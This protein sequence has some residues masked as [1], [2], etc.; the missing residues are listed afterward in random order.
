MA[1]KKLA[2]PVRRRKN[3][4]PSRIPSVNY[5][6][7]THDGPYWAAALRATNDGLPPFTWWDVPRMTADPT[8]KLGLA[9]R[10]ALVRQ[11]GWEVWCENEQAKD[12]INRTIQTFWDRIAPMMLNQYF[13]WGFSCA[14]PMYR[15]LNGFV[16]LTGARLVTPLHG[17]PHIWTSGPHNGQF[18][19]MDLGGFGLDSSEGPVETP[20]AIWFGG[21]EARCPLYDYS[22][23]AGAWPS[24]LEKNT[25]G[26]AIDTRR[27]YFRRQAIPPVLWRVPLGPADPSD[28]ESISCMDW[29]SELVEN[30]ENNT[31]YIVPDIRVPGING[32]S[33]QQWSVE[34]MGSAGQAVDIREYVKDLDKEMLRGMGIPPEVLDSTDTGGG[35]SGRQIPQQGLYAITDQLVVPLLEAVAHCILRELVPH[36]FGEGV[37]WRVTNVPLVECIRRQEQQGDIQG[38]GQGGEQVQGGGPVAPGEGQAGVGD[39]GQ[40][41]GAEATASGLVPYVGPH[42]GV[43]EKNPVTGKVY[44]DTPGISTDYQ[45]GAPRHLSHSPSKSHK[46][47]GCLIAELPEP[48]RSYITAFGHSIPEDE[49]A[50]EGVE[51][52]PHVTIRHGLTDSPENVFGQTD[53]LGLLHGVP[54]DLQIF[55][56]KDADVLYLS[57]GPEFSPFNEAVSDCQGQPSKWPAYVPHATVAYL[58]PGE[59][60][61][62]IGR[63]IPGVVPVDIR[64][65]AYHTADGEC[66]KRDL[67]PTQDHL[68]SALMDG[69][70]RMEMAN[71]PNLTRGKPPTEGPKQ[72]PK[73]KSGVEQTDQGVDVERPQITPKPV[74]DVV[75]PAPRADQKPN[76]ES[77]GTPPSTPVRSRTSSKVG[78]FIS[79]YRLNSPNQNISGAKGHLSDEIAGY[80]GGN[81]HARK[82]ADSE[83]QREEIER[84]HSAFHAFT[85]LAHPEYQKFRGLHEQAEPQAPNQGSTEA[86]GGAAAP[87]QQQA[88]ANNSVQVGPPKP[89]ATQPKPQ[90]T[91]P[92]PQQPASAPAQPNP[93]QPPTKQSPPAAQPVKPQQ[94]KRVEQPNPVQPPATQTQAPATPAKP[95][96][97]AEPKVDGEKTLGD[98][99]A[100]KKAEPPK[101]QAQQA[102]RFTDTAWENHAAK[103][104]DGLEHHG[105][106]DD[107]KAVREAVTTALNEAMRKTGDAIREG[108]V[109][110]TEFTG[111][112][113]HDV[114]LPSGGRIRATILPGVKGGFRYQLGIPKSKPGEVADP[115]NDLADSL[116]VPRTK[117]EDL[118]PQPQPESQNEALPT[119]PQAEPQSG[120]GAPDQQPKATP[121]VTSEPPV[122]EQPPVTEAPGGQPE[123]I[124]QPQLKAEATAPATPESKNPTGEADAPEERI[125]PEGNQQQH[126]Q[127][128]QGGETAGPS[129]SDR[130]LE[131]GQEQAPEVK[132]EVAPETKQE[133]KPEAQPEQPKVSLEESKKSA[134]QEYLHQKQKL[135][136]R[137]SDGLI[138][139]EQHKEILDNVAEMERTH[140]GL[141]PTDW[142]PPQEPATEP[143]VETPKETVK[144][145]PPPE[146]NVNADPKK[147]AGDRMAGGGS[148]GSSPTSAPETLA[149]PRTAEVQ[150]KAKSEPQADHGVK[151]DGTEPTDEGPAAPDHM[152]GFKFPS[153]SHRQT[154]DFLTSGVESSGATPEQK[155]RFHEAAYHVASSI[156]ESEHGRLRQSLGGGVRYAKDK[157]SLADDFTRIMI[158]HMEKFGESPSQRKLLEERQQNPDSAAGFYYPEGKSLHINGPSPGV[159]LGGNL[160]D[161]DDEVLT[162]AHEIGHALDRIVSGKDGKISGSL[163]QQKEFKDIFDGLVHLSKNES[164]SYT[165]R[166]PLSSYAVS[167]P[168]ELFAEFSRLIYSGY[169]NLDRVQKQFPELSEFFKKNNLW[170]Q[171][172]GDIDPSHFKG[173]FDPSKR[174]EIDSQGGHLD[175]F[176]EKPEQETGM[177]KPADS[178]SPEAPKKP[179]PQPEQPKLPAKPEPRK[180]DSAV[181]RK[182]LAQQMEM[183]FKSR[184]SSNLSPDDRG[185]FKSTYGMTDAELDSAIGEVHKARPDLA[186]EKKV[187]EPKKGATKK[188]VDEDEGSD[189]DNDTGAIGDYENGISDIMSDPKTTPQEKAALK[190]KLMADLKEKHGLEGQFGTNEEESE[191]DSTENLA[192]KVADATES[193]NFHDLASL[194][195]SIP[196]SD[197]DLT[198]SLR[199]AAEAMGIKVRKNAVAKTLL[200]AIKDKLRS[201]VSGSTGEKTTESHPDDHWVSSALLG[202][203]SP[204]QTV[205]RAGEVQSLA[206]EAYDKVT[207]GDKP[208]LEKLADRSALFKPDGSPDADAVLQSLSRLMSGGLKTKGSGGLTETQKKIAEQ[209]IK[210]AQ[211]ER[212][213]DKEEGAAKAYE[214]ATKQSAEKTAKEGGIG[215][216]PETTKVEQKPADKP[217]EPPAKPESTPSEYPGK[218][219]K[220][221][222]YDQAT[223]SKKEKL[224]RFIKD[225]V[226]MGFTDSDWEQ[227]LDELGVKNPSVSSSGGPDKAPESKKNEPEKPQEVK[228]PEQKQP[229]PKKPA[230]PPAKK[231]DPEESPED[232]LAVSAKQPYRDLVKTPPA[233]VAS[234]HGKLKGFSLTNPD[235]LDVVKALR[236]HPDKFPPETLD[237]VAKLIK[238]DE[239]DRKKA[240]AKRK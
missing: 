134:D 17:R 207:A 59:G 220:L 58:K 113:S 15:Q 209:T 214:D 12:W 64:Q 135:D 233:D 102:R 45:G 42:G 20:W 86:G 224:D 132:P 183:A 106:T 110:P 149:T 16:D 57:M 68:W 8:I 22:L 14:L 195:D 115:L 170:P 5:R 128:G 184:G 118:N 9:M 46:G 230:K 51:T 30:S 173:I 101:Q 194:P 7:N 197:L 156:P 71:K 4:D 141:G 232:D 112:V 122:A 11:G 99:L 65:L 109:D 202:T 208:L 81:K 39:P 61:K 192:K 237:E 215:A 143:K 191:S 133:I 231:A 88:E 117:P 100:P 35:Y 196:N 70:D 76:T 213:S 13:A 31:T 97:K 77:P 160:G 104:L 95:A 136:Q 131:V 159:Y 153:E 116:G 49:L 36:N 223:P 193:R 219:L 176:L 203:S 171:H 33:E 179:E 69:S 172:S 140:R 80:L 114:T 188:L 190:E 164:L 28:P 218:F 19:G 155:A 34:P 72:P 236:Q 157:K 82:E 96:P 162:Y 150:D 189:A 158:N 52:N 228:A 54:G 187:D 25:R 26:G 137:L 198:A 24:W 146:G 27:T 108:G 180:T 163:S 47:V 121:P 98:I 6:P 92:K 217:L 60:E 21:L 201:S 204:Q 79:D 178:P 174:Q 185:Y 111:K 67:W 53:K 168:S 186:V 44:Y 62:Y 85:G 107:H 152:P 55:H 74:P 167:K 129:G 147:M 206:K 238:K 235:R 120:A 216:T 234:L 29:A 38:A 200:G 138:T 205:E 165:K 145:I 89:P 37:H 18:F 2:V 182:D 1:K 84:M 175:V 90:Q 3:F 103:L 166:L 105:F 125:E 154:Y 225:A 222:G 148:G 63:R 93:A 177:R 124:Q 226:G 212:L 181:M 240:A 78:S 48:V 41:G 227:A 169:Y 73:P 130:P 142:T 210:D 32:G 87:Q 43:G 161:L 229:E 211:G 66:F 94:A 91:Q 56:N 151:T 127:G 75:P 119:P 126:S 221:M 10:A 144:P 83:N 139:P 123:Q 199:K 50:E 23:L 239:A 40:T